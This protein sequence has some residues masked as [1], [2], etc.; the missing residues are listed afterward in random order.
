M[1]RNGVLCSHPATRW[2][3][4][5][6]LWLIV[7]ALVVFAASGCSALGIATEG[8]VEQRVEAVN[9][10]TAEAAEAVAVSFDP[11]FPGLATHVGATFRG[12]P[13]RPPPVPDTSF[14]WLEVVGI[15]GA[16]FGVSVP[17]AVKVTNLIRDNRRRDQHEP[18]TMAEASQLG[19]FEP[20]KKEA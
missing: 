18:T 4:E 10:H 2:V 16:A 13:T 14:P 15:V 17:A 9:E 11:I 20:T 3:A 12:T 7:A 19:Y 1:I 5:F 6:L 8:Y